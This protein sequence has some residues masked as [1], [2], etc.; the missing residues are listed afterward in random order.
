MNPF[1]KTYFPLKLIGSF[2]LL[3]MPIAVCLFVISRLYILLYSIPWTGEDKI[4]IESLQMSRTKLDI[5]KL[6]NYKKGQTF[7]VSAPEK[8]GGGPDVFFYIETNHPTSEINGPYFYT[9]TQTLYRD[10]GTEISKAPRWERTT[11]SGQFTRL[12]MVLFLFIFVC[13]STL[14]LLSYSPL[15]GFILSFFR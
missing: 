6:P 11:K 9:T 15:I 2:F 10:Y 7:E 8:I 1:K 12:G 14:C 3:L 5:E 13:F 4:L